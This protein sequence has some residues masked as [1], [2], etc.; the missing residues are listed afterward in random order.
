[1]SAVWKSAVPSRCSTSSIRMSIVTVYSFTH[2]FQQLLPNI[3][4]AVSIPNELIAVASMPR[5]PGHVHVRM[6]AQVP[7][8]RFQIHLQKTC[9]RKTW[10]QRNDTRL[11]PLHAPTVFLSVA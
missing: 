4:V 10:L 2:S 1:M 11:S 7:A 3:D 8:T 5:R 6:R 9:L